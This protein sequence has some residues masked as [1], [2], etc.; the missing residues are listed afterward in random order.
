[1]VETPKESNRLNQQMK[2]LYNALHLNL[3]LPEEL[4]EIEEGS[5]FGEG[6]IKIYIRLL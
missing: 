5:Y 2:S 3:K 6:L 4:K 1:M